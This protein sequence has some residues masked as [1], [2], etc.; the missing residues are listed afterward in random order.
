MEEAQEQYNDAE[1]FI[2]EIEGALARLGY[3]I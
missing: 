1:K 3:Q 2:E